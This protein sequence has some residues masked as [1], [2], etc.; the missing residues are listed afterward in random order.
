MGVMAVT[1][2][3]FVACAMALV[4][5]ASDVE[6]SVWLSSTMASPSGTVTCSAS[7]TPMVNKGTT[8]MK[9]QMAGMISQQCDY[10]PGTDTI[11]ASAGNPTT[12]CTTSTNA[13]IICSGAGGFSAAPSESDFA[14]C[15]SMCG[16]G[17]GDG[18]T[19]R[20]MW[21][22][23]STAVALIIVASSVVGTV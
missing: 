11:C 23:M 13:Q 4:A 5:K 12:C 10:T 9:M 18:S 17:T 2:S 6:C 1:L 15:A 22:S 19:N 20:A 3:A 16:A 14:D 8:C 7:G 21:A